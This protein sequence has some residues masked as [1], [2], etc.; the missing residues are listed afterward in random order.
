MVF[1]SVGYCDPDTSGGELLSNRNEENFFFDAPDYAAPIQAS[2]D[3]FD[4]SG[5]ADRDELL[6]YAKN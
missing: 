5:H 4:L 2:I 6:E 3:Q 1:A